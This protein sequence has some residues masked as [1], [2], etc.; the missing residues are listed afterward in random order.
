[1]KLPQLSLRELFW[2]VLVA[3]MIV[4]ANAPRAIGKGLTEAGFPFAF[5][6]GLGD[7]WRSFDLKAFVLDA[8]S[9]GIVLALLAIA[10]PLERSWRA[11]RE[12]QLAMNAGKGTE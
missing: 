5:A 4:V 3:A 6:Q 7:K 1:M 8:L 11:K 2:L 10:L 9:G 12:N